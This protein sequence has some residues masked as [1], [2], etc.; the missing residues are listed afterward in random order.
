ML[1]SARFTPYVG[2]VILPSF[3]LHLPF[4]MFLFLLQSGV[5]AGTVKFNRD[6]RTLLS[7]RCF[8]CHGP[9]E[10]K[11]E[12]KL[13]LDTFE[14]ATGKA[15][16]GATAIVPGQPDQSEFMKRILTHDLVDVMPPPKTKKTPFTEA[17]VATLKQ[18]IK[19]GALYEGHW[20]FQPLLSVVVPTLEPR[21]AGKN[22]ID[23]FIRDR[24]AKEGLPPS[25]E[26]DRSTLIRRLS[27]DLTGLLPT[28]AELDAFVKDPSPD[29]YEKCVD[30][31]LASPHYGERWGRHWLDQA[32]YADSDGYSIDAER[33]MWP[34]RDWVIK[35]MNDDLPFDQFTI[36]QLA[37]DLLP[38]ATKAQRAATAFHRNTLINSEGGVDPEQYR[39]EAVVDRVNTT[40]AVW[41]GLTVGCAQ[42]HTHKYDPISHQEYYQLFTFFNT[43]TD[44]NDKGA[45]LAMA[46]G[47]IFGT[48]PPTI[49]LPQAEWEATTQKRLT[50]A[51]T[52][53][54]GSLKATWKAV[55]LV[56]YDTATGAGFV[57][58]P[59]NSLLS[60]GKGSF[61]DTY[62]VSF[63]SSLEKISTI[64]LRA[65][66]HESLPKQGPGRAGNGNFVLTK[67]EVTQGG[68]P[69]A[70]QAALA[71]HEQ[72]NYSVSGVLDDNAGT[73]WAINTGPGSKAK[74]NA[75]HEAILLLQSPVDARTEPLEVKLYHELNQNYLLG[76]FA[77]E[78]AAD[79]PKTSLSAGDAELLA[80]LNAA[81]K[82]RNPQQRKLIASAFGKAK[83]E[84]Q[85][86]GTAALMVME[87]M[88]A[89]RPTHLL[90]RGDF[91]RP[92]LA[93]GAMSP[94]VLAAVS[95]AMPAAPTEFKNRLD[96]AKWL[97]HSQNPLTPRVTVNRV[98]MHLFTRGLV[99]TEEDFG[100][101]GTPPSHPELLD[102]LAHRFIKDGWSFKK[103][104]RTIVTSATY[105]QSSVGR[106]DVAERD[107]RNLLLARQERTRVEAEII[108]DAALTA[109]GLLDATIG[110]P[111][112][113]P[114]Q[115]EGVYAFTQNA[116]KWQVSGGTGRF[117]RGLYTT[118]YR[119]AAHPLFSTF[120][121]PDF[122]TTC[123][124]RGRSNTPLQALMM[125]NNGAFLELAR[126]LAGRLIKEIPGPFAAQLDAR[127]SRAFLLCVSREPTTAER[128][129]LQ[130]ALLGLL[131]T[132]TKNPAEAAALLDAALPIAAPPAEAAA[133]TSL[134]RILF[135]SDNFLTRE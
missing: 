36:E 20:A 76:R 91:T 110:G 60:D 13:R 32:R 101:Q 4:L 26:A 56:D 37:G 51:K 109:S 123:T 83:D 14:G 95:S 43:C 38:K 85:P 77:L 125:A 80:A 90:Q 5:T 71:D 67:V 23:S 27:L 92:D 116:K 119:S 129:A 113:F 64:R 131:Q 52:P 130:G 9:D 47:E 135:N 3:P 15:K 41:M 29:A 6:V 57:K 89:P 88:P 121:A 68:K 127:V 35:S 62:R 105:R 49:P 84:R 70:V 46:P 39:I 86:K 111:S 102:W 10:Q 18:W 1:Q 66:T 69:V 55:S 45:T 61:N 11:R 63:T 87:E 97:V 82:S 59:D 96:L 79:Q 25:A 58:L 117:R 7:D 107:P 115:P 98:W 72:P 40:G 34:Y 114:V 30:R 2:S 50:D 28:P 48:T 106:S 22:E 19:E 124:R 112:V 42:C 108:R 122:Q 44:R 133:L 24:L 99:E 120:D 128:T 53:G 16:S 74:M 33:A 93:G 17:E 100:T 12:G 21:V 104:L 132:F 103:L 94:G 126:G 65:L 54:V 78:A 81:E 75:E 134:A 73:G 8:Q 118:F 31:L